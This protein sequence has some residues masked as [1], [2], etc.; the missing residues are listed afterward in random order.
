MI[1]PQCGAQYPAGTTRCPE[2]DVELVEQTAQ[3]SDH[4]EWTDD[5]VVLETTDE[6]QLMVARSLLEAESI[7]CFTEGEGGQ[8]LMATGPIRLSVRAEDEEAARALL[9]HMEPAESGEE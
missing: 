4:P 2:C 8:R 9:A 5:V 1:C 7:P 3:G 6:V